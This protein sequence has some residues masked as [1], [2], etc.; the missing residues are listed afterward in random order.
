VAAGNGG[1]IYTRGDTNLVRS[2]VTH[3]TSLGSGG[4]IYSRTIHI[5]DSTI[6]E[7]S[8]SLNGGGI[9]YEYGGN[10]ITNTT[11]SGNNAGQ[12]GGGIYSNSSIGYVTNSTISGNVATMDG[13]GIHSNLLTYL[14]YSTVTA[15]TAGGVGGGFLN[16]GVT[17]RVVGSIVSGNDANGIPNNLVGSF[18]GGGYNLLGDGDDLQNASDLTG[19][20][21]P[22]LGPLANN[23]GPTLTHVPLPGSPA[24]DGGDPA[25]ASGVSNV[26]EFDQ[27][28]SMFTRVYGS[29]ID[30]GSIEAQS[31]PSSCDFNGDSLCDGPDIDQLVVEIASGNH[32]PDFD[33]TGDALV[34]LNDRDAWLAQAGA[35]NLPSGNAYILGDANLDGAVDVSDFNV[36]NANKFSLANAWTLGDF[37]ASGQVDV[38]DFNVWNSN[39]FQ[40]ADAVRGFRLNQVESPDDEDALIHSVVDSVFAELI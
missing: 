13:G 3:N 35:M 29:S 27:R 23:G 9:S 22:M 34:D 39:K 15:N 14:E 36:W 18:D 28:G 12:H 30:I 10:Q 26:P 8:A 40:V 21:D 1:G 37:D 17:V 31:S 24:L 32:N 4:G 16:D 6:A 2:D 5:S 11:V 19:I 7:N 33:L 25:A 38:S 20:N